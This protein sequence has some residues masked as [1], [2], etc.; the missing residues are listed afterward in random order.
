MRSPRGSSSSAAARTKPSSAWLTAVALAPSRIGCALTMPLV[1]VIEPPALRWCCAASAR[2]TWPSSL[3][4]RPTLNCSGVI[5]CRGP[6]CSLP[7]VEITAS[8]GPVCA[9]SSRTL[10]SSVRSTRRLP[11]R[12]PAARMSCCWPRWRATAWPRVPLAPTRRIFMT[13][14]CERGWTQSAPSPAGLVRSV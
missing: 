9:N 6:K 12:R 2:R 14:P 10:A 13:A 7:V 5:C 8:T 11:L 3:S 4:C 1:S